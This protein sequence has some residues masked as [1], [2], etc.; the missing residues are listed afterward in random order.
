MAP[1]ATAPFRLPWRLSA[2]FVKYS[3]LVE[4]TRSPAF[5]GSSGSLES[6]I[7]A[8]ICDRLVEEAHVANGSLAARPDATEAVQALSGH[9]LPCIAE[10]R[11]RANR[12]S[13]PP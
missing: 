3:S 9:A 12:P 7:L 10:V 4:D 6:R 11:T 5:A 13:P 2:L 8:A 1:S